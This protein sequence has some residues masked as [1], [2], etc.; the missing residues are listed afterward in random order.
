VRRK[1]D[2][3]LHKFV[4]E[5]KTR[6][7]QDA[8]IRITMFP[9]VTLPGPTNCIILDFF[10]W[11]EFSFGSW[12]QAGKKECTISKAGNKCLF[13]FVFPLSSWC[14][15]KRKHYGGEETKNIKQENS[16]C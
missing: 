15:W 7:P 6:R 2:L 8:K 4:L 13:C 9:L 12:A 5:F 10:L 1:L 14:G 16:H 3:F 11:V